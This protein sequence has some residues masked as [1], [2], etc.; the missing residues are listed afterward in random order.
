MLIRVCGIALNTG[1]FWRTC[2]ALT[3]LTLAGQ[4]P[5]RPLENELELSAEKQRQRNL[6]SLV[7]ILAANHSHTGAVIAGF[8]PEPT[9][10]VIGE[11]AAAALEAVL[12]NSR[13]VLFAPEDRSVNPNTGDQCRYEF[14]LA[15]TEARFKNPFG[16]VPL[17]NGRPYIPP[18]QLGNYTL[19]ER[20]RNREL[21]PTVSWGELG[22]PIIWHAE[23]EVVLSASSPS[24]GI[25]RE[26]RDSRFPW[27]PPPAHEISMP[28]GNHAIEW[29]AETMSSL[30]FDSVIPV[31]L[32]PLMISS[33]F[34]F[35]KYAP[36]L[37]AW[38][39]RNKD[40]AVGLIQDLNKKDPEELLRK[41]KR[42]N[43]QIDL[44]KLF[45]KRAEKASGRTRLKRIKKAIGYGEKA[46]QAFDGETAACRYASTPADILRCIFLER[47][48][49][50]R[51]RLQTFNV[52]DVWVP[53]ISASQSA[54]TI[55]AR[56]VGGARTNRYLEQLNA[57][58]SSSDRCGIDPTVSHDA[59]EFLPLDTPVTVTWT[60][61]DEGPTEAGGSTQPACLL[62]S[63]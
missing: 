47:P 31:A 59:P 22:E 9:V 3:L 28:A 25:V 42:L 5:A 6:A 10:S 13:A 26:V 37:K 2:V 48:T 17:L 49:A 45:K 16:L 50:E 44:Q 20:G 41:L 15:Q 36:G 11:S 19:G 32:I 61:E 21:L 46:S 23:T 52:Y 54:L 30:M 38:K 12:Y 24:A 34:K 40:E 1:A 27:E 39:K 63:R 43:R 60:A 7:S 29:R 18:L 33:E 4:A 62:L 14:E 55:E 57:L 58:I 56:D 53:E 51:V 35:A 8:V